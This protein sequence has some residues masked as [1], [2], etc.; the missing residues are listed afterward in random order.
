DGIIGDEITRQADLLHHTVARV[1]AKR[2]ADAGELL[3]LA[4]ID[5]GGADPHAHLAVD[6]MPPAL[7]GRADLGLAARLAPP[8]LIGDEGGVLVEHRRL[9][10]RPGAHVDADLFARP[11]G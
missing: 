1:D 3:P 8:L 7:E 6:A 2:A 5:A 10:A 11:A 9:E 4:D